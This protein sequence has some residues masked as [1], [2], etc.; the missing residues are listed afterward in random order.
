MARRYDPFERM[1]RLFE[2]TRR[3]MVD[4]GA[5]EM[6]PWGGADDLDTNVTLEETDEGYVVVADLP[7]FETDELEV[8]FDDGVLAIRGETETAE[9]GEGFSRRR[10]RRIHEHV[11][12]PG[13]VHEDEISASYR[14]GVLEVLLP[15]EVA[16]E[17]DEGHRIDIN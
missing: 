9:E 13:D 6:E 1:N 17:E 15:A 2:Q 4:A 11:T 16:S 5:F 7:G 14:N 10:S 3:S 8:R 12:V